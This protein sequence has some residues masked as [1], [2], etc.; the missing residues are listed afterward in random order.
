MLLL[1][2]RHDWF[3]LACSLAFAA[4]H[5]AANE[6]GASSWLDRCMISAAAA[7]RRK[8]EQ[9]QCRY[10]SRREH[11]SDVAGVVQKWLV[12]QICVVVGQHSLHGLQQ[13]R[14]ARAVRNALLRIRRTRTPRH[15]G[16]GCTL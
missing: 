4:Y 8:D 14:P 16:I 13:R 5:S 12:I 6:S 15:S 9:R 11:A 1:N 2:E 3:L 7:T 10:S